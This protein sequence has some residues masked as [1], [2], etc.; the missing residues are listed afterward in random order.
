LVMDLN[1]PSNQYM[2]I[3]SLQTYTHHHI[4]S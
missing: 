4:H 1:I 2:Y 3:H